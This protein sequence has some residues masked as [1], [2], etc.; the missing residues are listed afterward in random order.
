MA[1]KRSSSRAMLCGAFEIHSAAG[2]DKENP[3]PVTVP[4]KSTMMNSAARVLGT[5][6]FDQ[7][8]HRRLKQQVQQER[9][10]D[11]Q[12]DLAAEVEDNK[13]EE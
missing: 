6:S 11:R 4:M 5:C 1:D 2:P 13:H 8:V 9:E 10:E 3:I 12:H 7:R